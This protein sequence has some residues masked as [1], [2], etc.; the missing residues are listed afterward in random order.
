M[1][2][3]WKTLIVKE[4]YL[5]YTLNSLSYIC[6]QTNLLSKIWG[7]NKNN[8]KLIS[9][10]NKKSRV[11]VVMNG[12][13]INRQDFSLLIGE[14]VIFANRGFKHPLYKKIA[15]KFH[16]FVDPKLAKGIWP[17][18]WL[19]E[20]LEMVPDITFVMP[21]RWYKLPFLQPYIRKGVKI[22][23]LFDNH[24]F[25]GGMGCTG[26]AIRSAI[27]FGYKEL[28]IT[29]FEKTGFANEL[30]KSASHFYGVNEENNLK[31]WDDYTLDFYMNFLFYVGAKQ[32][33]LNWKKKG[34][35]LYN[36]TEGGI[37]EVFE[38]RKFDSVFT[39]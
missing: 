23:W 8:S 19:D 3:L 37:V 17:V 28:Y 7:L 18:T 20:I 25:I 10:T 16:V 9:G 39:K 24:S 29:G 38:R 6:S 4:K 14:D 22:Y 33:A 2:I 36:V 1:N 26:A 35:N 30:L 12:P 27:K 5:L 21:A 34:I 31:N 13:S 32:S 11:V 15:P